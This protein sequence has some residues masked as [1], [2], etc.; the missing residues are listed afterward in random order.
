M[1][2]QVREE[3]H[4]CGIFLHIRALQKPLN[5][6]NKAMWLFDNLPLVIC[7]V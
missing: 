7:N 1:L 2:Q 6:N 4:R 3:M 5:E